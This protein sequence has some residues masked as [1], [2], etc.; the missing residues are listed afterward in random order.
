MIQVLEIRNY[1]LAVPGCRVQAAGSIV[2]AVGCG[3][4]KK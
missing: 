2:V 1:K 3:S 4:T